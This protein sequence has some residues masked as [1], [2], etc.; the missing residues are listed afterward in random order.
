MAYKTDWLVPGHLL[1]YYFEGKI[2]IEAY[3]AILHDA[4][5]LMKDGNPPVHAISDGTDLVEIP[6]APKD[7][8]EMMRSTPN[9]NPEAGWV[10]QV[11]PNKAQR[12]LATLFSQWFAKTGHFQTVSTFREAVEFIKSRDVRFAT[13]DVDQV[14][15]DYAV[16]KAKVRESQH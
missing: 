13:L 14:L 15:R 4:D 11:S 12:F 9:A 6:K 16:W 2:T 8:M 1:V 10:V 5:V 3:R 7:I